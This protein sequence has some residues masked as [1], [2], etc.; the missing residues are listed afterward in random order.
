MCADST[1][2]EDRDGGSEDRRGVDRPRLGIGGGG[3]AAVEDEEELTMF[4]GVMSGLALRRSSGCMIPLLAL[5]FS[6]VSAKIFRR[7]EK[8]YLDIG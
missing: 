5:F 7:E 1:C 2:V 3:M 4:E 8:K 6:Y